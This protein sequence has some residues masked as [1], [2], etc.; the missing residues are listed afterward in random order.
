M[1]VICGKCGVQLASTGGESFC[2]KCLLQL[3]LDGDWRYGSEAVREST[4]GYSRRSESRFE[5]PTPESLASSFPQLR[6]LELIGQGGMGAV[7]KALHLGLNRLVALKV[8]PAEISGDP[9]FAERFQR[10]AR[11]LGRLNHPNI[12]TIYD[13]GNSGPLYYLITEFVDGV[14]LRQAIRAKTLSPAQALAIIPKICDALQYAHEEGIVHRDIKPENILLDTKGEIKIADFGLAK[15]VGSPLDD[16]TLTATHQVLGTPRYMAPEQIEGSRGVDHRA[17][18][19]SLGVVFYEMLT[20]EL[21][22]GRFAAPSQR[23]KVDTRLDQVVF[24]TLEKEPDARYQYASDL[25]NDLHTIATHP[26]WRRS[27]TTSYFYQSKSRLLGLPLLSIAYGND[28]ITGRKL[29][30]R[31]WLAIGDVAQG[32]VALGGIASGVIAI[33][34]LSFGLLAFGGVSIGLL[35]SIGGMG[36]GLGFAFGGCA[37]G[38]IA[39]GGFA[40][41]GIATGGFAAGYY[42]VGGSPVG[43]H[44]YRLLSQIPDEH[45]WVRDLLSFSKESVPLTITLFIAFMLTIQFA[46]LVLTRTLRAVL[47]NDAG[48]P[49]VIGEKKPFSEDQNPML[50]FGAIMALFSILFVSLA[51]LLTVKW[52]TGYASKN[53]PRNYMLDRMFAFEDVV[54]KSIY[55]D[56]SFAPPRLVVDENIFNWS[57]RLIDGLQSTINDSRQEYDAYLEANPPVRFGSVKGTSVYRV[58]IP[59]ETRQIFIDNFW[60]NLHGNLNEA[61]FAN[62]QNIISPISTLRLNGSN[63]IVNPDQAILP[64]IVGW[65]RPVEIGI[66]KQEGQFHVEVRFYEDESYL[67]SPVTISRTYSQLPL[68]LQRFYSEE[69]KPND[70]VE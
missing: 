65:D 24:R 4:V 37:I 28:P 31:G 70:S 38:T 53:A 41:G 62:M 2:P 16:F 5:A 69:M 7:Y 60:Q 9:L 11:A 54:A 33:G 1:S 49:P 3:G 61:E 52:L 66:A 55:L 23:A 51:G 22:L 20:G 43:V 14:N 47:P 67:G 29:Y 40:V 63:E 57:P 68:A 17:D 56:H 10:E 19:Y 34:G 21:P 25:R 46:A 39:V 27:C 8:L 12:I 13:S 35:L 6:I 36:L 30:A 42:A 59:K 64:G 48:K 58:N 32:F 44:G 50:K 15:I 45:R 26:H 18:I